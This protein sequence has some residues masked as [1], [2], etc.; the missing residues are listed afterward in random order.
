MPENGEVVEP[1]KAAKVHLWLADLDA[2]D[3]Y[4][5]ER[6]RAWFTAG[7]E[8]QISG[9]LSE[10]RRREFIVGRGLA[11]EALAHEH[12]LAPERFEFVADQ[13]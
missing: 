3:A 5:L 9:F 7:E 13:Q 11:R 10:R 12:S 1:V 4:G 6:Y 8:I 2:V